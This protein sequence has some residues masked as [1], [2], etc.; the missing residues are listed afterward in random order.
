MNGNDKT[1]MQK[2]PSFNPSRILCP[3]DFSELS[4]LALKYAAGGAKAYGAE[5]IVFHVEQFELPP[6]FT[7]NQTN[8]LT[9]QLKAQQRQAKTYLR[10]YALKVLGP[11][12]KELSI[13]F[14]LMDAHPVDSVL[15]VAKKQRADLIVLGT[16]GRGGAKR[17]WLGSVAENIVRQA[18]VPVFVARQKQHEFIDPNHPASAPVLKTILCPVNFSEAARAAFNVANSIAQRFNARL[19]PVCVVEPGD[20]R[21]LS[22]A[23]NEL[24]TWVK[25]AVTAPCILEPVSRKGHAAEQ[26][27]GLAQ[28]AKADLIVLGSQRPGS[29]GAWLMGTTTELVLRQAT[30]P[31]LVV[32]RG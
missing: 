25:E 17:L 30:V 5:L 7:S 8:E 31:V 11:L 26:I 14:A 3:I 32:P 12:A 16:H 9:K 28:E 22:E 13:T 23:A 29:P 19:I 15:A 21:S 24:H 4:S 18:E 10:Q 20:K 6:Y 1:D 27:V 2:S